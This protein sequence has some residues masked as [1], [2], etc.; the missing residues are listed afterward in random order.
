LCIYLCYQYHRDK[1]CH[2][3]LHTTVVKFRLAIEAKSWRALRSSSLSIY[4]KVFLDA[5]PFKLAL[6]AGLILA[7]VSISLFLPFNHFLHSNRNSQS[8]S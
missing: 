7:F 3:F 6:P 4:D 5:L 2:Y 1:Q 8:L